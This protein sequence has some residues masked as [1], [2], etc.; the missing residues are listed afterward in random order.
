[1][2]SPSASPTLQALVNFLTAPFTALPTTDNAFRQSLEQLLSRPLSI[3]LLPNRLHSSNA[4]GP[5]S[6]RLPLPHL[7]KVN[8][9]IVVDDI[10]SLEGRIHLLSN[11][12]TF[13][14]VSRITSLS[15]VSGPAVNTY[16]QLL[17]LLTNSLPP[18]ALEP[19]QTNG[20]DPLLPPSHDEGSD[21]DSDHSTQ[22]MVV[23]SF[24]PKVKLP[25]LD[26]RTLTRVQTLRSPSYINAILASMQRHRADK[27][28]L[29]AWGIALC[30]VWPNR[31]GEILGLFVIYG[32]GGLVRELYRGYVRTST[33]GQDPNPS[34]LGG[35]V[36]IALSHPK[37][38]HHLHRFRTGVVLATILIPRGT[39]H[40]G[41][42]HDGR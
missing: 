1:M 7:D 37:N 36:S 5:L 30:N 32:G 6:A 27:P 16:V 19:Q 24:L 41:V 40:S 39:V 10:P 33:I 20:A 11:L 22:V 23:D 4:L 38:T 34:S 28:S 15:S 18:N 25:V 17:A 35:M 14:P 3:P 31:K 9:S 13:V 26:T 8:P 21:S 42:T 29:F 12:C 2:S